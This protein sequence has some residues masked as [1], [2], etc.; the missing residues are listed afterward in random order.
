MGGVT[1]PIK[2][3]DT[4]DSAVDLVAKIPDQEKG[5]LEERFRE[6]ADGVECAIVT[7]P[8]NEMGDDRGDEPSTSEPFVW[9]VTQVSGQD[10][11]ASEN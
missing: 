11:P 5:W 4:G 3:L 6:A 8:H 10:Q 2:E 7:P 9:H 1:L